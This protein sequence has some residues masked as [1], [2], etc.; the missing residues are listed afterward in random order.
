MLWDSGTQIQENT[1]RIEEMSKQ[2]DELAR[3]S[4]NLATQHQHDREMSERRIAALERELELIKTMF[5]QRLNDEAE[6]IELRLR[7]EITQQRQL[8]PPSN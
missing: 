4:E 5:D 8:P 2:S 6:K 1:K 3:S 7:L